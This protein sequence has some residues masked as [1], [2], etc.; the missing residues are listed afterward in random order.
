FVAGFIGSPAMNFLRGRAHVNGAQAHLE[1]ATGAMMA[2]GDVPPALREQADREIVIGLRPED[3][4]PTAS[5]DGALPTVTAQLE[6]IEPVGNEIFLN[7]RHAAGELVVRIPPQ[8]L[9]ERGT[10]MRLA[11]DP[12]CLHCFDADSGRRI[13]AAPG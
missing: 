11:F 3:L 5:V 1:L 7:L 2:L 9:P 6:V 10:D 12:A 13:A 4:C 8:R